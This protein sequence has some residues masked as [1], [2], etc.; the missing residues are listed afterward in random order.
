MFRKKTPT[1]AEI[2]ERYPTYWSWVDQDGK[3]KTNH[4]T[5]WEVQQRI[6]WLRRFFA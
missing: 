5:E 4:R 6:N 1:A 3:V 2:A